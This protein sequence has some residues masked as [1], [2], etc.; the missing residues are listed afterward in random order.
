MGTLS[1]LRYRGEGRPYVKVAGGAVR[2]KV[3][4]VLAFEEAGRCGFLWANL[5]EALHT[6]LR[7][8]KLEHERLMLGLKQTLR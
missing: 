3:A 7:L 1:G 4:D 6:H 8:G 5:S 2:Y